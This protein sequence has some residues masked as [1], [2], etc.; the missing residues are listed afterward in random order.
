MSRDVIARFVCP[1]I[2]VNPFEA[3]EALEEFSVVE[4]FPL[5]VKSLP[6]LCGIGNLG[7]MHTYNVHIP[8]HGGT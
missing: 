6:N 8:C 4:I 7:V 3:P 5:D 2:I 1:D